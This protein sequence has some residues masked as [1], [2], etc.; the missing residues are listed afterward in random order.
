MLLS[1]T[2]AIVL[3]LEEKYECG[4]LGI[5]FQIYKSVVNGTSTL[6]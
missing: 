4:L 5:S 1:R 6:K 2:I 3:L